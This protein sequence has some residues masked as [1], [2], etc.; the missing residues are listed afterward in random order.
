MDAD[1]PTA[2]GDILDDRE[3]VGGALNGNG[4]VGGDYD[5]YRRRDFPPQIGTIVTAGSR[6]LSGTSVLTVGGLL[7]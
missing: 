3:C 7:S 6:P 2:L 5:L 4:W 1:V